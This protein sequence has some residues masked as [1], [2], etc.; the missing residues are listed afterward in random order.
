MRLQQAK[1]IILVTPFFWGCQLNNK[2]DIDDKFKVEKITALTSGIFFLKEN[3]KIEKLPNEREIINTAMRMLTKNDIDVSNELHTHI[4]TLTKIRYEE[5]K[6]NK[7]ETKI[8]C[9]EL[10]GIMAPFLSKIGN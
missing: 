4:T 9:R 3:C 10:E 6:S 1:I 2:N 5:I 7:K 8:K